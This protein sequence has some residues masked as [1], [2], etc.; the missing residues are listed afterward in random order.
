MYDLKQYFTFSSH[1]NK[2][3]TNIKRLSSSFP[4][5]YIV[6]TLDNV[7]NW[8]VNVIYNLVSLL[9]ISETIAVSQKI[10]IVIVR[11]VYS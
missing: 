5:E 1:S 9:E 7:I 6:L 10:I 8:E 2:I 3:F 11:F 4:Q